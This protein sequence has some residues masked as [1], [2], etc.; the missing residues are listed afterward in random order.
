M[1]LQRPSLFALLSLLALAGGCA[2][3][4]LNIASDPPGA[5]V[6]LNG[7][8]VGRTPMRYDFKWYGDYDIT[9]RREGYAT[10]KTHRRLT[11]PLHEIPPIDLLSEMLGARDVR[12]WT[13]T[14]TPAEPAAADPRALIERAQQ[15][16]SELR[17]SRYTR[18]PATAP[19]TRPTTRPTS[20]ME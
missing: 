20:E 17:S 16:K 9:L 4:T 2:Q 14:L 1:L 18:P 3:R 19:T 7:Q 13:F 12:D 15:L 5:L 8:E 10:L 6:Y 11:P